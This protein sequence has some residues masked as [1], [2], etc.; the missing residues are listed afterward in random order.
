MI[1]KTVT[2]EQ[3]IGLA[4]WI[5]LLSQASAVG[6]MQGEVTVDQIKK[7][8]QSNQQNGRNLF[9]E[10]TVKENTTP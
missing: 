4:V 9:K 8:I 7:E 10:A 6:Y 1:T 3:M 5:G 2:I